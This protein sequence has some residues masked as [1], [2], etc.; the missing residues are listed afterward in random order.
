MKKFFQ[1]KTPK[2]SFK[3]AVKKPIPIKCVQIYEPFEVETM[4]GVMSGKAGDWLM[5]GIDGE[6]YVC[7]DAI[8]KRSYDIMD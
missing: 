1:D 6:K 3:K 7:D 4:E 8:F 2:L 5:I